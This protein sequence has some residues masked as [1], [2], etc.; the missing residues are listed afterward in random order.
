M[1]FTYRNFSGKRDFALMVDLASRFAADHLRVIDLPYRFS[2]WAFDQPENAALWFGD[3][4]GLAGWAVLQTPF[5][6]VDITCDPASEVSL[7]P[8]ILAWV[9][10][11]VQETAGTE[12]ARPAWFMNIFS[13]QSARIHMLEAAGFICQAEVGEDS[14]SKVLM[15]RDG[16]APVKAYQ[17]PA[18]FTIRPLAGIEEVPAYVD[19]HQSVFE[20]RNMTVPWRERTLCQESYRPDLDL[21]ITA[22]DGRLA[23]FCIC[24]LSRSPT[25]ALLGQ[26]EP[27]GCHKAFRQFALGRVV[28]SAGLQRIKEAG[29]EAVYVETDNYRNAAFR[30]YRFFDFKVIQDVLVFRKDYPALA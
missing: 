4:G 22:P 6:T 20:S 30:L 15:R 24:W 27:L 16:Q 21:V 28:L 8:Q 12:F 25:G 10:R 11:R 29:V 3:D 1:S 18:G 17:P 5:W 26:V 19:L 9:D 7:Y 13:G 2:S 23:A 14:W